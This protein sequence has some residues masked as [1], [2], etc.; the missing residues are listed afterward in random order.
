MSWKIEGCF[1]QVKEYGLQQK[2]NRLSIQL[3]NTKHKF[4]MG[5]FASCT[6][7]EKRTIAHS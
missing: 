2:I 1:V 5:E 4:Y 7:V 3:N 6:T